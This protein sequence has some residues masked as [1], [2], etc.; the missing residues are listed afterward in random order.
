MSKDKLKV[1]GFDPSLSNWGVVIGS[2][3]KHTKQLVITDAYVIDSKPSKVKDVRTNSKDIMRAE[4]LYKE[5]L[6]AMED[7]IFVSAEVPVGSQTARAMASYGV[8]VGVVAALNFTLPVIQTTAEEGK[9]LA[10]NSKTASKADMIAWA[11]NKHPELPWKYHKDPKTGE[12]VITAKWAE[13]V[14][15]A[16]ASLYV[17]LETDEVKRTV[18]MLSILR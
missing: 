12:Q 2:Y 17:M 10:C 7:A 15:D 18:N 6:R 3:D 8:C 1:V 13:H 5:S 16:L 4:D 14:A 11:M 9:I